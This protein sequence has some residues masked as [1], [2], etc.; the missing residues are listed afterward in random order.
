[1][2]ARDLDAQLIVFRAVQGLGAG[3]LVPVGM[4]IVADVY[5]TEQR[6]KIQGV[7]SSVWGLAS[8]AGPLAGGFITDHLSWPWV[9][10]V[11][12]PFGLGA[13]AIMGAALVETVRPGRPS[14]EVVTENAERG[15]RAIPGHEQTAGERVLLELSAA[16]GDER[17]DALA[18]VGRLAGDEDA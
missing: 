14:I 4:T 11:N 15:R 16:E 8:I 5:T 7:F 10:F 18:E 17:V 9:F 2:R 13:A 6:A 1:M 3:A 12:V